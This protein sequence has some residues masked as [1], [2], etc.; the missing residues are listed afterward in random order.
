VPRPAIGGARRGPPAAAQAR[1]LAFY[2]AHV[3]LGVSVSAV[4]GG[5]GRDV[6]TVFHGCRCVEN[7]RDDGRFDLA[8]AMVERGLARLRNLS[9]RED[10]S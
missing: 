4:S 1:Q 7:R 5:L 9:G 10:R 8:V 2:L 6:S 3:G